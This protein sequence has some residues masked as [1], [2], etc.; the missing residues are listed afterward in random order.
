MSGS[1]LAVEY[2]SMADRRELY[3]KY[4]I[5]AEAAQLFETE[6]GTLLLALR[7]LENDWHLVPDG[8]AAKAVL[9]WLG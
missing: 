4:G 9:D 7:G 1:Q 2:E 5:A 3:A 6:L 8:A